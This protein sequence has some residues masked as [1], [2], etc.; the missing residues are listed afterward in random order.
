MTA[1]AAKGPKGPLGDRT[2]SLPQ[3]S[4][5]HGCWSGAPVVDGLDDPL[6]QAP[7][8]VED[9]RII[10]ADRAQDDFQARAS[11]SGLSGQTPIRG[12]LAVIPGNSAGGPSA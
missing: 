5:L 3:P 2:T 9:V 11:A 7:G 4:F 6:D 8:P 10:L 1:V 12:V